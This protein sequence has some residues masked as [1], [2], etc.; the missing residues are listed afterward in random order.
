[1]LPMIKQDK[2]VVVSGDL[3]KSID[4]LTLERLSN[5]LKIAKS[6]ICCR[7]SPKDKEYLTS[8]VKK[9]GKV[10][11]IGDGAN[12]VNMIGAAHVG[13]GVRGI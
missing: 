9:W 3:I 1:M 10:L 2:V 4:D 7:V 8:L 13:V 5:L 12:D 6:V 11:A